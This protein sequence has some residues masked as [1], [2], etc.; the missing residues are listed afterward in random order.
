MFLGG[1]DSGAVR[2]VVSGVESGVVSGV[3]S[4][5]ASVFAGGVV[6]DI[7]SVVGGGVV[8][9]IASVVGSSVLNDIVSGVVTGSP[10][11]YIPSAGSFASKLR[12][13]L[14]RGCHF[15]PKVH[16]AAPDSL[17]SYFC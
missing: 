3:A 1:D 12:H 7:A 16:A 9:G 14:Q 13:L 15:Q 17:F 5:V 2:G 10:K 11:L 4:G 8:I 6:S